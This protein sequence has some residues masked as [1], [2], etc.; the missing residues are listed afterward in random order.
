MI[1]TLLVIAAIA[2]IVSAVDLALEV[3]RG[4]LKKR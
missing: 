3:R 1:S 2:V 4:V